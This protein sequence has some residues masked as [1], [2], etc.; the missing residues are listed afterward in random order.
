M[1]PLRAPS[2]VLR[3]TL[4]AIAC[5]IV[6][7]RCGGGSDS[8]ELNADDVPRLVAEA[9]IRLGDFDDPAIGFSR[10][11]GVDVDDEGN[12]YV[13]E[14]MDQQIRVYSPAGD[15]LRRIGGP[16]EGPGEFSG[17]PRFGVI[18]DTVWAND[19]QG[20]RITLFDRA[21]TV[22]ST[23]RTTG[24]QVPL[25]QSFGYVL[26]YTMRRDGRFSGFFGRV[27]YSRDQGP[28]GVGEHD[29]IRVPRVLF[30]PSG[31]VVDTIGWDPSPPPRMVAP[32]GYDQSNRFQF[33]TVGN[34]RLLVPDPPPDLAQWLYLDDGLIIV[35]SP[36]PTSAEDAAFTVTRID[37]DGDTVYARRFMYEPSA[38][39]SADL[40]SIAA[41]G[42]RGGPMVMGGA[43]SRISDEDAAADA[44]A[45]R[46]A[47][48][49]PQYRPAVR[50]AWLAK[51]VRVWIRRDEPLNDGN[52]RWLVLDTDGTPVGQ[53]ELPD[54]AGLQWSSGDTFWLSEP[55]EL[56][57]PWLVRYRLS[58]G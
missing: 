43:P 51:D 47:M 13:F 15:L 14:G 28:T 26:P 4:P 38:Y 50:F 21:G 54:R 23:G 42:A 53:L 48:K 22:L 56:D 17:I 1:K 19:Q 6:V 35:D 8:G 24:V 25:P 44:R 33:I 57:V 58:G 11:F 18:G 31:A 37:L 52:I 30:D 36:T 39:T 3:R 2:L 9:D 20:A 27:A 45:L 29:P 12:I 46:A 34:R 49:F 16:G 32:P 40:D 41:Q 7:A 55:D 10:I 5:L